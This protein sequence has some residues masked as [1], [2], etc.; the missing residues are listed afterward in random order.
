M[1]NS[2]IEWC[3]HTV[4]LWWGCQEV[5][6][7]CDNCYAR[8]LAKRWGHDLW[9]DGVGRRKIASSFKDLDKYQKEASELNE[10]HF[11]FV[12]SMMDIFEKPM[13]L[14]DSSSNRIEG[15]TSDLRGQ[16]FNNIDDGKY[17]N[18]IFLLLTKRPSNINK[19]IPNNWKINPPK[20]VIF[21][22]SVVN[23][24]TCENL[25]PQ[26]L[27]VNGHRFL[28]VE[29]QLEELSLIKWLKS[30]DIHWVI[31]GGESGH[32]KR[33][34]DT[35]WGRQL[36]DECITCNVPYFFKQIDK[37]QPIPSDLTI[38]QFPRI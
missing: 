14:I 27:K 7:G 36:R 13:S 37:I 30:G 31:Q 11:V 35:N 1:K 16:F 34:F 6:A 17:E 8:N 25:I 19:Y 28:S 26:L 20:N 9:Q 24:K 4:N 10:K 22:T 15:S 18:L 33:P 38:R 12:G 29:P 2:N 23:P 32:R 21:G 3:H 5:H